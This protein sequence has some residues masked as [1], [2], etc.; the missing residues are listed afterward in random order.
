MIIVNR[1][2]LRPFFFPILNLENGAEVQRIT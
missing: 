1:I 2:E